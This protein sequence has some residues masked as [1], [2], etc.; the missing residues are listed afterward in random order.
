MATSASACVVTFRSKAIKALALVVAKDET[1][2]FQVRLTVRRASNQMHNSLPAVR[3]ATVELV[4]KYVVD[5]PNLAV[6]FMPQ[7]SAQIADKGISVRKRVV[8]LL[9]AIYLILNEEEWI[10]LKVDILHCLVSRIHDEETSIRVLAMNVLKELWFN[11]LAGDAFNPSESQMVQYLLQSFWVC[12]TLIPKSSRTFGEQLQRTLLVLV[13]KP[14]LNGGGAI[15]PETIACFCAV[16]IHQTQDYEALL[17]VFKTCKD[18]CRK[19]MQQLNDSS[20]ISNT[21]S[22]SVVMYLVSTLVVYGQFEQLP[23]NQKPDIL[24]A[25]KT[26]SQVVSKDSKVGQLLQALLM[27]HVK[28]QYTQLPRNMFQAFKD[29][30]R[31][32]I[33][34]AQEDKR[35][36]LPSGSPTIHLSG[37]LNANAA[38]PSLP[39]SPSSSTPSSHLEESISSLP[40]RGEAAQSCS[41]S[42]LPAVAPEVPVEGHAPRHSSCLS[43]QGLAAEDLNREAGDCQLATASETT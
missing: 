3:D 22:L 42:L 34:K 39:A 10:G 2:F 30:L 6:A 11:R 40:S 5:R 35:N 19:D 13:N 17:N 43:G 27:I 29:Y 36:G 1:V 7:I 38:V 9:K 4:G 28:F 14:N 12:V 8:K 16:V 31:P 18:R 24:E 33:I 15:L 32:L 21:K 26:I 25:L 37:M 23:A 20:A 41:L